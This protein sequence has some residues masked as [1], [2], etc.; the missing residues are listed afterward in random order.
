MKILV[1]I[2]RVADPAN[3]NKVK[4]SGAT[5]THDGLEWVMNPFDEWALE[6]ALRLTENAADKTRVGEI[7]IVSI[8]PKEAVETIREALGKGAER[9]ILVEGT[10]AE[11][12][13]HV[14]AQVLAKIVEKEQPDL[15]LMG[16]QSADGDSNVAG[17]KLAETLDWPI[18][19]YV[20]HIET[21]DG[22]KTL[23]I[24]RELDVGVQTLKVTGPA[25]LT[26]SDRILKPGTV[27]NGVTPASFEYGDLGDLNSRLSNLKN[28]MAGRKKPLDETTIAALGVEPA[29]VDSYVGFKLP[30]GRSGNTTYLATVDELVS[31]LQTEAKVL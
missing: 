26:V 19:N 29:R 20:S 11:L 31:K 14:V 3:A 28:I 16:K 2:K 8:G 22:G 17:T 25:V 9:G 4:V 10:D 23:T 6:T 15:V 30:A 5:V 13:S 24:K 21:A 1:P 27:K 18:L 7:V 12:D